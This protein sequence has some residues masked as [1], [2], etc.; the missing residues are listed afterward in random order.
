MSLGNH[1]FVED[2][3]RSPPIN[4]YKTYL[5]VERSFV[6]QNYMNLLFFFVTSLL[7]HSSLVLSRENLESTLRNKKYKYMLL[8]IF[9]KKF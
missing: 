9:K 3:D 5:L 7:Q 4:E 6:F 8:L 2:N 1:G